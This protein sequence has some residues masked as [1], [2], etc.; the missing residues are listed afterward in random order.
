MKKVIIIFVFII[1]GVLG[2]MFV[3]YII[4]NN[5]SNNYPNSSYQEKSFN[6]D[7]NNYTYKKDAEGV[8]VKINNNSY[9]LS[10]VETE[11]LVGKSLNYIDK[12]SLKTYLK[13]PGNLDGFKQAMGAYGFITASEKSVSDWC[14]PYYLPKNFQTK[15][16]NQ[17]ALKKGKAKNIIKDAL[18][19]NWE[20][21]FNEMTKKTAIIN[22]QQIDEDYKQVKLQA[23][24]NGENISKYDYCK[25]IDEG[26]DWFVGYKNKLFR[27]MYPNF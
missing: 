7:G 21:A 1:A 17:F 4:K 18:G 27:Q 9:E 26:A 20:Q 10:D 19:K 24:K 23:N 11:Q 13:V 6:I 15:L 12:E 8:S 2:K 3:Q 22:K 14:K 5:S 25:M 16:K